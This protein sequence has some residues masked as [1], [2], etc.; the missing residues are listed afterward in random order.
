MA[1]LKKVNSIKFVMLK[2]KAAA[3]WDSSGIPFAEQVRM[4]G[5]V[6]RFCAERFLIP[7]PIGSGLVNVRFLPAHSYPRSDWADG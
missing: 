2:R 1:P 5:D 3:S 4:T 6:F 7:S